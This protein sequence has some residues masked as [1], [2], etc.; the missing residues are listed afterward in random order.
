MTL[1]RCENCG[2]EVSEQAG[3]CPQCG[4][5]VPAGDTNALGI[6]EVGRVMQVL[7][8]LIAVIGVGV[9][10]ALSG[11]HLSAVQAAIVWRIGALFVFLGA[12]VCVLGTLGRRQQGH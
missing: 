11:P 1:L 7:G 6:A 9:L 12:M 8:G 10:F 2:H 3:V 5:T 4:R